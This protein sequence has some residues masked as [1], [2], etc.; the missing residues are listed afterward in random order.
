[1]A[2]TL[3]EEALFHDVFGPVAMMAKKQGMTTR[4]QNF[5]MGVLGGMLLNVLSLPAIAQPEDTSV[6]ADIQKTGLLKIAIRE[7][8]VPFGFRD[9]GTNQWT[10]LCID[11]AEA[12]KEQISQVLGGQVLLVKL[13]RSSL[14][15]RFSLIRD[16]VAAL[17]WGLQYHP[18]RHRG[19]YLF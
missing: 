12:L 10:G 16:R 14:F 4:W 18:Q 9:Q 1:M 11:F 13:Y 15:N 3:I 6:L 8:A 7:D 2:K 17:E 5:G 19:H